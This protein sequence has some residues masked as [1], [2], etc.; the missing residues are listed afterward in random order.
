M[1]EPSGA[2][3]RAL[4][5]VV[6][7][8]LDADAT[9]GAPDIAAERF[10]AHYLSPDTVARIVASLGSGFAGM[11]L[12]ERT[13]HVERLRLDP[14][15]R[16]DLDAAAAATLLAVY[17]SWSGRDAD[18]HLERMPLGWSLTGY[19]NAAEA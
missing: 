1:S 11:K 3:L 8:G 14:Q 15:V 13:E 9:A 2:I 17:G 4:G 7:P 18:G 19:R 6:C 10:V 16:R 5:E 12:L